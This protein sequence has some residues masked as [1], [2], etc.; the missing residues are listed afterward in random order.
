VS[1]TNIDTRK[2]IDVELLTTYCQQWEYV[3]NNEDKFRQHKDVDVWEDN[4]CGVTGVMATAGL[5]AIFAHSVSRLQDF[6]PLFV[7]HIWQYKTLKSVMSHM[8]YE[9][10]SNI[11]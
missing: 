10:L 5:V 2:V 6:I 1:A 7:C 8:H 4:F 11:L 3:K 9:E